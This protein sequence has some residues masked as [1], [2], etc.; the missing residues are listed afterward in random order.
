[1]PIDYQTAVAAE[2]LNLNVST[3][4]LNGGEDYE[5]LFTVPLSAH[6]LI[7]SLD[8]VKVIGH[9][10]RPELG[11]PTHHPRRQRFALRAQAGTVSATTT[12]RPPPIPMAKFKA[13][14]T[15][16]S[17]AAKNRTVC[18]RKSSRF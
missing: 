1:M 6:T 5:L 13:F 15:L 18:G 14:S 2:E 4:A 12:D 3:C 11:Q 9:I 7:E 8:D 17:P 10:T 16:V